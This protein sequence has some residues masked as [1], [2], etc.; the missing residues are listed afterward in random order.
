MEQPFG[1]SFCPQRLASLYNLSIRYWDEGWASLA[2]RTL[3][4][5][6]EMLRRHG[7]PEGC[8]AHTWDA[9]AFLGSNRKTHPLGLGSSAPRCS[10]KRHLDIKDKY[11]RSRLMFSSRMFVAAGKPRRLRIFFLDLAL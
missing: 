3:Q 5:A 2:T 11:L 1:S 6:L 9:M 4:G 10:S 8:A 7:F